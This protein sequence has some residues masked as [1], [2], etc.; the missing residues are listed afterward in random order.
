MATLSCNLGS[1]P[2]LTLYF[3]VNGTRLAAAVAVGALT[4]RTYRVTGFADADELLIFPIG[5]T[6]EDLQEDDEVDRLA[7][8]STGV[9]AATKTITFTSGFLY[10]HP[11]NHLVYEAKNPTAVVLTYTNPSGVVVATKAIGDLTSVDIGEYT[12][13]STVVDARGKWKVEFSCTGAVVAGGGIHWIQV[14]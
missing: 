9:V 2:E 3:G 6:D 7:I 4:A 8:A 1:S 5:Q 14:N 13:G 11:R 10:A 12:Y